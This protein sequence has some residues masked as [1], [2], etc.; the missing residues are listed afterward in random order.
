MMRT[1]DRELAQK[2]A[3]DTFQRRI[4]AER[5]FI[6]QTLKT[7]VWVAGIALTAVISIFGFVGWQRF[8]DIQ[9]EAREHAQKEVQRYISEQ[10][11]LKDA[12]AEIDR[13]HGEALVR[14]L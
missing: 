5:L 14:T 12:L 1:E 3:E 4:E 8:D 10:A 2:I 6:A 11:A 9:L 13:L 7:A